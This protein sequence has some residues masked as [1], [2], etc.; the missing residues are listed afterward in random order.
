VANEEQLLDYLKKVT[1]ELHDTRSR[2]RELESSASE[3][4]AIVG[5]G[6]RYPGGANSAE[7]LWELVAGGS[8]AISAFPADRG[9]DLQELLHGSD[10]ESPYASHVEMGGFVYDAA[11]FDPRFFGIGARE[12][13]GMDPQQ[14]LL[15]ESTWEAI[16][17]AGIDPVSL[18]GSETGAF[19]GVLAHEYGAH[20]MHSGPEDLRAYLG[21]SSS[22]SLLSG[23][24]A[25][26]F[27]FGGPA[28]TVNT[29]CS[30][31]LVALHLACQAL[32]A[33][34][35]E[36]AL[37]SGVT[38]MST[39]LV[40]QQFSRMR[41]LAPDGRCKSFAASADGTG[42]AEGVAVVLL[43]RLSD[44]RRLGHEVLAVVR[45]SAVN[46]DG[47]SSGLTAPNGLAQQR[48]IRHAL[49]NAGLSTG[50]VDV[51]EAHGTG[52]ELGDPIE[53]EA[54]LATY[55]QDRAKPL[56]LGSIK[57]NIGHTQ[58]AAG[59]AGVIK[60]TMAMR[61]GVLPR[62]LH[63]EEPSR[64]VEWSTG[65]IALLTEE[66]PWSRNGTPRRAGISSFGISGTNAHVILEEPES[67]HETGSDAGRASETARGPL[68]SALVAWPLSGKGEDGLRGQAGRLAEHIAQ[69]ENLGLRDVGLSLATTR[70]RFQDRA[71]VVG[72]DRTAMLEALHALS[73]GEPAAG[74]VQGASRA[75]SKTAFVFPGQGSEWAGMAAELL[76]CSAVFGEWLARCD[77]ALDPFLDWSLEDVLRGKQGAPGFDRVEVAQPALFAMMVSLA[78]L[79]RACGVA[80][81]VVVGH[82][83]GEVA[84][85]CVAGGL[86]LQDGARVVALRSRALSKL[87]GSGGMVSIAAGLTEVGELLERRR[88]SLSLAA[89]N[90]PAAVVV[91]GEVPALEELLEECRGRGL[92][93]RRIG[94]DVAGHTARIEEIRVE[95][96]EGC[97]AITP[98]SS[99]ARFYSTLVGGLLDTAQ[100]DAEYWYRNLREPVRF[101][102]AVRGLLERGYGVF[103]EASPHPVLTIGI[104]E[105][106][107]DERRGGHGGE[108]PAPEIAPVTAIGSLRRGEG[109]P[110]R[111]LTSLGEAWSCGVEVD[112]GAHLGSAT[113]RRVKLP[114]YAF[115]RERYWLDVQD[116]DSGELTAA[117]R[118]AALL[119]GDFWEAVESED[120]PRLAGVLG[121][122]HER[123][124][125]S[126]DA[127]LPA[128]SSWR[129]ERHDRALVEG[130]RYRI[131][132][133]PIADGASSSLAGVWAVVT[134][135]GW[136]QDEWVLTV[137]AAL[138]RHGARV[139]TID[140]GEACLD[141]GAL[142]ERLLE[143]LPQESLQGVV[144]LVGLAEDRDPALP[145]V[146][147]GIAGSLALVQAL[148]DAEIAA[149]LWIA[150]RDAVAVEPAE[151]VG[152]PL[153]GMM[154]GLGH[155]VGWESPD[156]WGG[157]IDLPAELDERAGAHLCRA[158]AGGGEQENQLAV[159]A[160]GL[161]ARRL[162][163]APLGS[164]SPKRDWRPRG[165]TLVTGGTGGVGAHLARWLARAGAEH[166]LLVS[167]SGPRAGGVA[168]LQIELEAMGARVSI[169]ACDV[170]D[171][172]QLQRLLDGIPQELPLSDVFH[173]AGVSRGEWL[174][175]VGPEQLEQTLRPK[176]DAALQLHEL[177]ASM[178][179]QAFVLFSSLTGVFG[180][181]KLGV[182]AAGNAFLDSL[183]HHRRGQGL[184]ATSVSWGAWGGEG[185]AAGVEQ[186]LRRAGMCN[187]PPELAIGALQQALDHDET[188]VVVADLDWKQNAFVFFSA[189]QGPLVGDLPEVRSARGDQSGS[190]ARAAGGGGLARR[191]AG[192]SQEQR[193]AAVLELV[194]AQVALMLE[195]PSA[196][197]VPERQAFIEFGFDSLAAIELRS[198][199]NVATGLRLPA[200]LIFDQ[201]NPTAL[202]HY[203]SGELARTAAVEDTLGGHADGFALGGDP[204][205]DGSRQTLG[206]LLAQ[207]RERGLQTQFMGSLLAISE[208]RPTFAAQAEPEEIPEP[209]R[210]SAGAQP[211]RVICLPSVLAISGP[212]QYVRF[213]G[214][215][216]GE[217]DVTVLPL[218][219][220]LD[221]ERLPADIDAAVAAHAAAIRRLGNEAPFVLAGHS[222][223]G[224]LAY[225]LAGH[226]EQVGME[227]AGVVL[228]DAYAVETGPPAE[229]VDDVLEGMF[230]RDGTYL[231]A[232]DVRLTAMG[233]YI[234]LLGGWRPTQ[235]AAPVLLLRANGGM[236]DRVPG[237]DR[238]ASWALFDTAIDVEGDH[239]TIMEEH[240]AATAQAV[241]DW[242]L[243][244]L[245]Q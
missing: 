134:A 50:D 194:R 215:F 93:A 193:G 124:R 57:S 240:S 237:G 205:G 239:F 223:G 47:A 37:A 127:L 138:E 143:A 105:T 154:W 46:Q 185:M 85:A 38:V 165:T 149:P 8:D 16:E 108:Q 125:S 119:E 220:F 131:G 97:A 171:R 11:E 172:D 36:L 206:P 189:Q 5:I 184:P 101:D 209:V 100:L 112:W 123:E 102:V 224:V 202:A 161:R 79:W 235:I 173:A 13:L 76:D 137:I 230:E 167:R 243:N 233:A 204:A 162:V 35:C 114:T 2:L 40:F 53:A 244:T 19:V 176:V 126:L 117:D 66:V 3:P 183:A 28:V 31:S 4:V 231:S 52:T 155:G 157:L 148:Q 156:R 151:P 153:Q 133:K 212:H 81:D 9:W 201:P 94:V 99:G 34:D 170:A 122:S 222:S 23:R 179:L 130:W 211:P 43:E 128:L 207:A 232:G 69:D 45:G 113:A 55:G 214:G 219:G 218:P 90:G 145:G 213:A 80:P 71:V 7:R 152:S 63:A 18:R 70:A 227:P 39:P 163:R 106:A 191:L 84:A 89:V 196:E 182:Y 188:H 1:V 169:A 118:R 200:T 78:E 225:A 158:L 177:T 32:R 238:K 24:V 107:E 12:A 111:F 217:R 64:Q 83:Q 186:Q 22:S 41:G 109:G 56:W 14:R 135:G 190:P 221:G 25:Y 77:E 203:L 164:Q 142:A 160:G 87:A 226:L 210:L 48:V 21:M 132:W 103:L 208:F 175:A 236:R 59:L 241:D 95:V 51:V 140:A 150:T 44:A 74:V 30:S 181:A 92:R 68:G 139:V 195:Q 98:R 178:D 116:V 242:L 20:A 54:L 147:R 136:L 110:R 141:R 229:V 15:L 174:R 96:L 159:R 27:G 166:I 33:G 61:H 198:R 58:A 199:L 129:R 62:T 42:L 120:A 10:P 104:Q 65:S 6:C 197:A 49:A 180:S 146:V 86:S 228:I 168:E 72:G 245:E 26:L 216:R 91:S 67:T 115:Q 60:M 82:S 144:S 17:D 75:A 88:G 73:R 29:A 234:R 192:M 121:V 187:M